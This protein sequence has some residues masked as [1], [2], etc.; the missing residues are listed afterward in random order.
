M[1]SFTLDPMGITVV[2]ENAIGNLAQHVQAHGSRAFLVSDAG[3]QAAGVLETVT[4]VLT[5]HNIEWVAFTG[6]EPNPTDKNVEA[7]VEELTEFGIEGTVIVLVGGGSVMDC[8][9]YIAMAAPS[10][11]ND[12]S[13]AFSPE[14]DDADQIDFSTLAPASLVT[15]PCVPTIAVPTTSGTASETNGGGLITR[16]EDHRKLTFT[17]PDVQPRV[18]A[19]PPTH[20]R[21]ASYG[22]CCMR[23]GCSYSLN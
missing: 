11:I 19:R 21:F 5:T 6:V 8:G 14:L 3:I 17:H 2:G 9:K 15:E 16:T 10:K 12:L 23:D 22:D 1:N 20:S 18:S 7:G 13:L 4:D